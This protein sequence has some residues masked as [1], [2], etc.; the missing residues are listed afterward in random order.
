M[1]SNESWFATCPK[2]ME[3]LLCDELSS[4]GAEDT[5]ETVGG[6]HFTGTIA[7]AYRI[8]LWS[9]LINR[10]LLVLGRSPCPDGDAL[11]AAVGAVD[12]ARYMQ[13]ENSLVIDFIG[14]HGAIRNTRYGAQLGKDAIVDYFSARGAGRPSVDTKHP[15]VRVNLRLRKGEVTVAIDFGGGSLH[16]RGYRTAQGAAPLKENLAAACL[17]RA[18]WPGMAARGGALIDPMC[19]SGTLLIEAA[20]MAADLAPRLN[21]RNWGFQHL[22]VH[23]AAQ[24]GALFKDAQGRAERGL[25]AQLPEIRGYDDSARVID[26]A[27][28][29]IESAGLEKVVRVSRKPVGEL[30]KPTH[31][32]IPT[33]LLISNPPYG[34]RLGSVDSL[35]HLYRKLGDVMLTE[36]TGWQAALLTGDKELGLATGLRSHRRYALYNGSLPVSLLLFEL[37]QSSKLPE[38]PEPKPVDDPQQL[39]EAAQMLYNR[40]RKNRSKWDKWARK[41]GHECYRVY[42]ADLPEYAVAIDRYGTHLHVAEYQAPASVAEERAAARMED[43]RQVVPLAFECAGEQ[44]HYKQRRRQR[45]RDQYK[46]Q[47]ARGEL[48]NVREGR[49]ELLVNLNDYLDTG[50]F[51]DHRPLR[52]KIAAEAG[53]THFLNLFCYTATASVHA[54][55]G[56][57]RSTTSVDL[58]NTY[59]DWARSNFEA[60]GLGASRHRLERSD[61]RS[62]LVECEREYDLILLDPPSFS[63]S[64]RMEG[65]LDIQRDHLELLELAMARLAPE[66]TL[67]FSNNLR[68]FKL[69]AAAGERWQLLDISRSTIDAD[70]QRRP[71]IHRC[72]QLQHLKK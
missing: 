44:V 16:Q 7:V 60:N 19:G 59:L 32:P 49:A 46:R 18:D 6:C 52:L 30:V 29:N 15:D 23:N 4:L 11:L 2:G 27:R 53:G 58:S 9:R 17:M 69:D 40:L 20:A 51:L 31:K 56:G 13:P 63:N 48:L 65:S 72:W 26:K 71:N 70:F 14:T 37:E 62:W 68:S 25:A 1:S 39:S 45:G 41:Q 55:L 36:F 3:G 24:W 34:E 10:L 8:A 50:L 5:R 67:Y 21:R 61:V 54:A 35:R 33:G 64:K 38:K 12:W 57:A 66:G 42:D 47:E 28:E 43:I 22:R